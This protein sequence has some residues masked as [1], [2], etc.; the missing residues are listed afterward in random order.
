MM[1]TRSM[2]RSALLRGTLRFEIVGYKVQ[3]AIASG[4]AESSVKSGAFQAGG[5]YWALVCTFGHGQLASINLDLLGPVAAEEDVIVAMASLR[6]DDPLAQW[7]PAEWQSDDANAFSMD[8]SYGRTSELHVPDA[9][10]G[11]E[12]RYVRDDRLI[13]HCTVDVLQD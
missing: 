4:G 2:H 1:Y 6:I 9:F 12:T 10:H 11:H 13:I 3:K 7:P 5:Y 8:A